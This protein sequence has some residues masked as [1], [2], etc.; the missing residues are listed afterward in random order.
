MQAEH[1]TV[2]ETELQR[3]GPTRTR[4]PE[5]GGAVAGSE[6]QRGASHPFRVIPYRPRPSMMVWHRSRHGRGGVTPGESV[7]SAGEAGASSSGPGVGTVL[8]A[9][10]AAQFVMLLDSSVMNVSIATVA[11]DAG[12][13][14]TGI[15][16]AITCYTLVMAMFMV[17]GGKI[18]SMIG[19]KRAFVIGCFAYGARSLTTA[20]SPNLTVL[21]IG[22]SFLE[23]LGAAL[24]LPAIVGL[25]AA[26]VMP[27]GRPRAF[28]MVMGAGAIAVAVGPLIGGLATTYL[29]WR[30][31]FARR[32]RDDRIDLGPGPPN[33]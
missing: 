16:T 29:S 20:L 28:G 33:Q 25:V 6:R 17:T 7:S 24:I 11:R 18:G 2:S 27:P 30:W 32:G 14:V 13:T 4:E 1:F 12:T 26:N 8:A 15:Q 10:A 21:I 22:W 31:V 23:G 5:S 19:R 9:L 3:D